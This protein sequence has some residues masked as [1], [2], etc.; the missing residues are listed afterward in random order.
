MS[1]VALTRPNSASPAKR[2]R[3]HRERTPL[4]PHLVERVTAELAGA[5]N[6]RSGMA[7]AVVML[8]RGGGFERVEWWAPSD[9]G[10]SLRLESVDG[11]GGGRRVVFSLGPAGVLVVTGYGGAR[12]TRTVSGLEPILRRR[13]TDEQLTEKATQL[14]RRNEALEDFAAL[15]AHELKT[16]LLAALREG[17]ASA[18]VERALDIVDSLLEAARGESATEPSA[19]AADCLADALRDLGP[20][21]AEIVSSLPT[22]FPLPPTAFRLVLRNL[23]A[24]A[25]A[26]GARN[27]EIAAN[28]STAAWTL[29]VDDD[30]VGLGEKGDYAAGSRLGLSLCRRIV[31]R[32]GGA[33]ELT[34]RS[35]GGTRATLVLE[36]S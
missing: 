31:E 6:V 32:F 33:L 35:S 36:R 24:N 18:G 25:V 2:T 7:R 5:D 22:Q 19:S 12:L 34:P 16:P 13:W 4:A 9:Q 27:I 14:A 3:P 15:V 11:A 26:A 30:G 23:V 29:V 28:A 21:A 20:I 10:T 8:R 1:S 17:D